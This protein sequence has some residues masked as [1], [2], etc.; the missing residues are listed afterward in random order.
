MGGIRVSGL[1][2]CDGCVQNAGVRKRTRFL[3]VVLLV[4]VVGGIGWVV[5]RPREPVYQ[6]KTLSEWL[7]RYDRI[8]TNGQNSLGEQKA[9]DDAVRHFGT[10][11]LPTLLRGL[12]AKES[13]LAKKFFALVKRQHVLK[14]EH[15]P[16]WVRQVEAAAGFEAL[17]AKGKDAVPELL[18]MCEDAKFFKSRISIVS[19]L[20]SI[21]PEA[22]PAV[23][24]LVR[25][26]GDTNGGCDTFAVLALGRIH[27]EPEVGVPGLITCLSN[28]NGMIRWYAANALGQYGAD[29]KA[30]VP[31]LHKLLNDSDAGVKEAAENALWEIDTGAAAKAG[32]K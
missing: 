20:G 29:A 12:R 2:F 25:W 24:L 5:W 23:P 28:Q 13:P 9:I 32:V 10:N 26:L 22:R 31:D 3:F 8:M 15:V 6:G 7:E 27:A 17:G 30:A 18:A 11:A 16:A 4:A 19:A 14:I 21:G 1:V